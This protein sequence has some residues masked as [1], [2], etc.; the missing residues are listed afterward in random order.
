MRDVVNTVEQRGG[1]ILSLSLDAYRL[2]RSERRPRSK[3][4]FGLDTFDHTALDKVIASI[5]NQTPFKLREYDI[6][7]G[8]SKEGEEIKPGELDILIIEGN[9]AYVQKKL[10]DLFDVR[11]YI[12]IPF[13]VRIKRQISR[14]MKRRGYSFEDAVWKNVMGTHYEAEI[15]Q[16]Q[17]RH[18][19]IIL[20]PVQN[21]IYVT[22]GFINDQREDGKHTSSPVHRNRG[23]DGFVFKIYARDIK[24]RRVILS[25]VL[26]V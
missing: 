21:L 7:K 19:D 17:M 14:D 22:H 10:N 23:A 2:P 15:I 6:E 13:T 25:V 4:V 18:A 8:E 16:S 26:H 3:N 12:D 5:Q 9:F 1:R 20:R 24:S 11:I